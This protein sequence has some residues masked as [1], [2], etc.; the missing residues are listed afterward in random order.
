MIVIP[1]SNSVLIIQKICIMMGHS[2][3]WTDD[4]L[5]ISNSLES[6]HI[7]ARNRGLSKAPIK[8]LPPIFEIVKALKLPGSASLE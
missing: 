3:Y 4:V 1:N 6:I 8:R 5:I 2:L 7:K